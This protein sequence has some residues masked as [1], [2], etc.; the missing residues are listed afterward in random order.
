MNV[1]IV[2]SSGEQAE[3]AALENRKIL[4]QDV[5]AVFEG[6]CFIANPGRFR[7][8]RIMPGAPAQPLP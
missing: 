6:D 2:H 7:A 4:Q 5:S 3:V 1:E 8:R